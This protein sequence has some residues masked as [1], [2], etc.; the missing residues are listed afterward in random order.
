MRVLKGYTDPRP[1]KDD[2][3]ICL[4]NNKIK[5]LLN[6]Q[7]FRVTAFQ[8]IANAGAMNLRIVPEDSDRPTETKVK[9]H[10]AFFDGVEMPYGER[11]NYE[12]FTF[13]YALT[14][15]KAQGSQWNNVMLFDEGSVFREDA[16]RWRYTAVTRA[17]ERI[18][19]VT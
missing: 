13:G 11:R 1:A 2:R 9:T 17:A 3:V 4:R 12:E 18:T 5:R 14:V 10:Q 19:V 15:H 16:S 7:Q 8:P 6:G